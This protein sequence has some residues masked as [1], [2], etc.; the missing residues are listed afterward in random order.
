VALLCFDLMSCAAWKRDA[1]LL[2]NTL[3]DDKFGYLICF[4]KNITAIINQQ[5]RAW[6]TFGT[7]TR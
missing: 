6:L 1:A 4:A 3:K 5:V 7:G 2:I